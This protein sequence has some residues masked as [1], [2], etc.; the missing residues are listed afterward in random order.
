LNVLGFP[1]VEAAEAGGGLLGL[2]FAVGGS[3]HLGMYAGAYALIP[4]GAAG[5]YFTNPTCPGS[6]P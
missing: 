2:A 3:A 1:E 4:G 6:G 5:A